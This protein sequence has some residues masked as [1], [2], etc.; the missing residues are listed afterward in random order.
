MGR[1]R[2]RSTAR[3][4]GAAAS[5]VTAMGAAGQDW[6]SAEVAADAVLLNSDRDRAATYRPLSA[7]APASLTRAPRPR[8]GRLGHRW[9]KANGSR[10]PLERR[11]ASVSRETASKAPKS[12]AGHGPAA[13][14]RQAA[15]DAVS[16]A[17]DTVRRSRRVS[18]CYRRDA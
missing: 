12:A 3:K 1:L 5:S 18:A 6:P 14:R 2:S 7:H 16:R 15:E 8:H 13:C 10:E 17:V 9:P 4:N 11:D